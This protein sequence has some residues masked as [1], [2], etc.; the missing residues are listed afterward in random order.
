MRRYQGTSGTNGNAW[1]TPW[2]TTFGLGA[3]GTGGTADINSNLFRLITPLPNATGSYNQSARAVL[4]VPWPREFL[5]RVT[6]GQAWST[7]NFFAIGFG[8]GLW[9]YDGTNGP[10]NGYRWQ[11]SI[12]DGGA[13]PMEISR[14]DDSTGTRVDT[15]VGDYA[16]TSVFSA[17]TAVWFRFRIWGTTL[18]GKVWQDGTREPIAWTGIGTDTAP[19][20]KLTSRYPFISVNSANANVTHTF[21]ID[22]IV[23]DDLQG[24]LYRP[25]QPRLHRV[26]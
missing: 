14:S 22:G 26:G 5:C 19:P 10:D 7:E 24:G 17:S 13:T 15:A 20:A 8:T 16:A 11:A 23:F 4:R 21:S 12:A 9:S 3:G 18:L 25:Q 6:P 1:P 2:S